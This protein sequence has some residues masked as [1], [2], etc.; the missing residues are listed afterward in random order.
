M[1]KDLLS[2]T[3][4]VDLPCDQHCYVM[5]RWVCV[6]LRVEVLLPST[7]TGQCAVSMMDDLEPFLHKEK[8][9]E[10]RGGGGVCFTVI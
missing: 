6:A 8:Q 3:G 9:K 5:M 4:L 2:K 1:R 7:E 10:V